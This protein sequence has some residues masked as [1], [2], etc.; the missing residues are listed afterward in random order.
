[1]LSRVGCVFAGG[2]FKEAFTSVRM[3]TIM[4]IQQHVWPIY[5]R[6]YCAISC[7]F[8]LDF[9]IL[10]LVVISI[11]VVVFLL[12]VLVVLLSVLGRL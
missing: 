6:S 4:Y 2:R 11:V 3:G 8:R 7:R 9:A 12:Y 1:M 10:L 5:G